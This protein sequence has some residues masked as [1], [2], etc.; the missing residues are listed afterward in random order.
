M[1]ILGDTGKAFVVISRKKSLKT[2]RVKRMYLCR[3]KTIYIK[4]ITN[5]VL[6]VEKL[7]TFPIN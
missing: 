2:I 3:I 5:I 6:N 4:P 7:K 1:I